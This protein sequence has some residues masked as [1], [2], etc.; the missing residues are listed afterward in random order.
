[1]NLRHLVVLAA[2][3]GFPIM[4]LAWGGPHIQY[5][6]AGNVNWRPT[7]AM[8]M[9]QAQKMGRMVFVQASKEKDKGSDPRRSIRPIPA[10]S[11]GTIFDSDLAKG[12]SPRGE[13]QTDLLSR[14]YPQ[15][16]L[17]LTADW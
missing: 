11:P 6:D 12:F 4:E 10:F 8:A 3:V 13:K 7:F 14:E 17:L 15:H 1:M 2:L 5:D 9:S 16:T